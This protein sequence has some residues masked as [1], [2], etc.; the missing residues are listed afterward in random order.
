MM[1][2]QTL[3]TLLWRSFLWGG[4][5]ISCSTVAYRGGQDYDNGLMEVHSSSI[6]QAAWPEIV[7]AGLTLILRW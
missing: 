4:S 3:L 6:I 1:Q 5:D 2:D 7:D